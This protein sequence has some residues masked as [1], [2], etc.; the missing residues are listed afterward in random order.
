VRFCIYTISESYST[1]F[2]N[3]LGH[4]HLSTTPYC[5]SVP[6]L[7]N[8]LTDICLFDNVRYESYVYLGC[9]TFTTAGI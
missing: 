4:P 5:L 2:S 6:N 9:L 7:L 3:A 8:L 1:R